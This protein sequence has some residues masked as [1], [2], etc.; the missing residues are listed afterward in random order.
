MDELME[1]GSLK[2]LKRVPEEAKKY[3]ITVLEIP[4]ERHIRI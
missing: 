2:G 3:F 4:Y 1:K